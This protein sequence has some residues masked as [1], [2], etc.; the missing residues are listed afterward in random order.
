MDIRTQVFKLRMHD[1]DGRQIK[2]ANSF[3][4]L[5][6]GYQKSNITIANGH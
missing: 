1:F 2:I 3:T 6:N 4:I 5:I